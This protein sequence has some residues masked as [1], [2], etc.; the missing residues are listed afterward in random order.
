MF[1]ERD[2][3]VR[4]F[5]VQWSPENHAL[6]AKQA[7]NAGIQIGNHSLPDGGQPNAH[8]GAAGERIGMA[9]A[10]AD[11]EIAERGAGD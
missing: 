10:G 2:W 11:T 6:K 1:S 4:R 5:G 8:R 7:H 9:D 3:P